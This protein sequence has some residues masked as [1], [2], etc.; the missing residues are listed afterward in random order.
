MTRAFS[1]RLCGVALGGVELHLQVIVNLDL[2]VVANAVVRV[3][4]LPSLSVTGA[5]WT[6]STSR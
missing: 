3:N 1:A 4:V 5:E 6:Y 2:L